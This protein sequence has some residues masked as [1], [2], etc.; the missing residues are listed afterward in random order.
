MENVKPMPIEEEKT[1]IRTLDLIVSEF[2][3]AD[4]TKANIEQMMAQ[5][6]AIPVTPE[7]KNQYDEVKQF[8]I[9]SKKLLTKIES[10]RK[11]LKAP[12]LQKGKDIDETARAAVDLVNPL[13]ELS[14]SRRKAWEDIKQAEKDEEER[15]ERDR[16][17]AV[18]AL[19]KELNALAISPFDVSKTVDEIKSDISALTE[20]VISPVTFRERVEEAEV[21][22]SNAIIN[23]NASLKR[24]EHEIEHQAE[25]ARK[26]KEQKE[27]AAAIAEQMAAVKAK[28]MELKEMEI[29]NKKAIE[30]KERELERKVNQIERESVWDEAHRQNVERDAEI[31]RVAKEKAEADAK[32]KLLT[33]QKEQ[34]KAKARRIL[35]DAD[36][37]TVV[38]YIEEARAV[39]NNIPAPTLKTDEAYSK[40]R[41]FFDSVNDAIKTFSLDIDELI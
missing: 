12:I 3:L 4:L 18:D 13:I 33:D 30:E 16:A 39:F 41:I 8:N 27:A 21:I 37:A 28:E 7:D 9:S 17:E 24:L 20:F 10:R 22:R 14:G 6:E 25:M 26:E 15:I 19:F 29:A 34:E 11:E 31:A 38:Q 40:Y 36:R 35:V 1:E 32:E 2:G 23:A 5:I